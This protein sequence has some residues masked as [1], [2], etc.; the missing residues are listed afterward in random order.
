MDAH[1]EKLQDCLLSLAS[2]RLGYTLDRER[3]RESREVYIMQTRIWRVCG[4]KSKRLY[5]ASAFGL[6]KR[7]SVDRNIDDCSSFKINF[8]FYYS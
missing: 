4:T 3:E 2:Y 8:T 1:N 7:I 6:S 5:A